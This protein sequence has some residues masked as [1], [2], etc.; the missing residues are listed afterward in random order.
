MNEKIELIREYWKQRRTFEASK[1]LMELNNNIDEFAERIK[2]L[3]EENER[4][5]QNAKVLQEHVDRICKEK[6]EQYEKVSQEK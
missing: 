3:E 5:K 2:T 6:A 4:L 1:V